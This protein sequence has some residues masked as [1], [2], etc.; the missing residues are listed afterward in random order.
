M[1]TAMLTLIALGLAFVG[2][3]ET[4]SAHVEIGQD[5]NGDGD[6]SDAGEYVGEAPVPLVHEHVCLPSP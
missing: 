4:A 3:A 6:C 5:N 2:V 1:K